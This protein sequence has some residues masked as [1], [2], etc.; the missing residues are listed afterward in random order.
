LHDELQLLQP[1][2][3]GLRRLVGLPIRRAARLR[4]G[5]SLI[6]ARELVD[7]LARASDVLSERVDY[8]VE[9]RL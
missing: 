2:I 4:L 5:R 8:G 6:R 9:L 7:L 1:A 3:R